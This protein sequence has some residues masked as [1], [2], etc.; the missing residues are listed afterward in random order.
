MNDV[1][2]TVE[3]ASDKIYRLTEAVASLV[4]AGTTL[5]QSIVTPP[6]QKRLEKWINKVEERLLFLHQTNRI[7]LEELSKREDFSAIILRIIH[8]A[9]ATSQK[10]QLEYLQNFALNVA[11]KPDIAEDELYIIL[12]IISSYTPS[13]VKVLKFYHDPKPYFTRIAEI[14]KYPKSEQFVQGQELA[15]A[16][17]QGTP[18]YWQNVFYLVASKNV[19]TNHKTLLNEASPDIY[20][21][22]RGTEIGSRVIAMLEDPDRAS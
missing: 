20:V 1:F 9:A 10:E 15:H 18:Y 2:P 5:L 8:I 13:H 11:L 6:I 17:E 7:D 21:N 3:P 14:R 16:F 19:I 22:G 12:D 4:P